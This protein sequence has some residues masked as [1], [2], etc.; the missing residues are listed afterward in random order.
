MQHVQRFSKPRELFGCIIQC[1]TNHGY[2]GSFRQRFKLQGEISC[3]C[4][5]ADIQTQEHILRECP[6]YTEARRELLQA[7]QYI[8]LPEI[9]G[10]TQGIKALTSFLAASGA[11]TQSGTQPLPPKPPLFDNKPVP[12]SKDNKSDLDL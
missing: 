1:H 11:Y 7:S 5:E 2:I 6:R 4:G 9:L 12:D 8:F 10:T 3:P